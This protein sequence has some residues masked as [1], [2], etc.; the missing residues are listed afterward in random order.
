MRSSLSWH[1]D[2]TPTWSFAIDGQGREPSIFLKHADCGFRLGLAA[3]RARA[4]LHQLADAN[5][6]FA[7]A[8]K[9]FKQLDCVAQF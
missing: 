7:L 9:P 3:N 8:V 5:L 1:L 2:H 6:G 4:E